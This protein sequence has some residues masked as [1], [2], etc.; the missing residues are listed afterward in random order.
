MVILIF[1]AIKASENS[2]AGN[3]SPG[4]SRVQRLDLIVPAGSDNTHL[5]SAPQVNPQSLRKEGFAPR[6]SSLQHR[7][8][9]PTVSAASTTKFNAAS[10]RENHPK[11]SAPS[12]FGSLEG[13]LQDAEVNTFL[14]RGSNRSET[15]R[16][17]RFPS[18]VSAIR[19]SDPTPRASVA[20]GTEFAPIVKNLLDYQRTRGYGQPIIKNVE[21]D[22]K[23]D[24]RRPGE[25]VYKYCNIC[26]D[27]ASKP[28]WCV[29]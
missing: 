29:Q 3:P 23:L 11:P 12:N 4:A 7:V 16:P 10:F 22:P 20:C 27:D 13:R 24:Q 18:S 26:T 21:V 15:L 25:S 9:H 5:P 2:L 8:R 1:W 14:N 28:T 19:V 17:K 6:S